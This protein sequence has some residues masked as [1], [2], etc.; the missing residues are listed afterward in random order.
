MSSAPAT[1]AFSSSVQRVRGPVRRGADQ[2][3]GNLADALIR[4]HPEEYG[5]DRLDGPLIGAGGERPV[6]SGCSAVR[7]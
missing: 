1:T 5:A 3:V 7:R 2:R 4:L 6:E